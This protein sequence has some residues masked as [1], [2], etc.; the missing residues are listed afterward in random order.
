MYDKALCASLVNMII[1]HK[2][3]EKLESARS[4]I[5]FM[6][7]LWIIIP[8][9]LAFLIDTR[10][11]FK[12]SDGLLLSEN[13]VLTIVISFTIAILFIFK[14]IFPEIT[15]IIFLC[16]CVIHLLAGPSLL[17]YDFLGFGLLLNAISRG[18]PKNTKSFII[19]AYAITIL[20]SLII[21]WTVVIGSAYSVKK[22]DAYYSCT[23]SSL[24]SPKAQEC[25]RTIADF[26]IPGALFSIVVTT[27]FVI[28]GYWQR[29]NLQTIQLLQKHNEEIQSNHIQS[30]RI[31]VAAERARIA[32]DMHDIVAHTLSIIIVQSDGGRYA[33]KN[34]I[35]LARKT[36]Y[37]I[38]NE[39]ENAIHDMRKLLEAL[40]DTPSD[41][42]DLSNIPSLIKQ[43]RIISPNNIF[44]HTVDGLS[45]PEKLDNKS[46]TVAYRVV[47]ESL[48]NIRKHAGNNIKVTV[49][50]KWDKNG[51]TLKIINE[52]G[53]DAN[54]L[55]N[56]N[57]N[58]K[59]H[60]YG[61]IGM[62]ERIENIN[63]TLEY[64]K[65]EDN[66]FEIIAFIPYSSNGLAYN[67]VINPV[68]NSIDNNA[69]DNN[70]NDN[71]SINNNSSNNLKNATSY[72]KEQKENESNKNNTGNT[73]NE[74]SLNKKA[75]N[76]K[77]KYLNHRNKIEQISQWL[78]NHWLIGDII[79]RIP[80]LIVLLFVPTYPEIIGT[81]MPFGNY[82][83]SL[84]LQI[85]YRVFTLLTIIPL[86]FCRKAPSTCAII[87]AISSAI[88]LILF[89]D[90]LFANFYV[91]KI[92]YSAV[93]YG[94]KQT[95]Q[96]ISAVVLVNCAI[97]S[98]KISI[99]SL[100]SPQITT[101]IQFFTHP[102]KHYNFYDF[103]QVASANLLI[104]L[105]FSLVFFPT[106]AFAYYRRNDRNNILLLKT[107]RKE[108]EE[109]QRQ[110]QILIA[111]AE[112]Q[113]ISSNI[114]QEVSATLRRVINAA[115]SGISMLNEYQ[116]ENSNKVD[117]AK[118][119]SAKVDPAKV[120]SAKVDPAN[121]S[122]KNTND[123]NTISDNSSLTIEQIESIAEAFKH[124]GEEGRSALRYMRHLLGILRETESVSNKS[125][126]N[127]NANLALRPAESLDNQIR[128]NNS[129][130]Q[131]T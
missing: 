11:A 93:L 78:Q 75:I 58:N 47:Q 37:I 108:L 60:G 94:K 85:A 71:N 92:I 24:S 23:I 79:Y 9:L 35:F 42:L 130:Q 5:S 67:T 72:G 88:Q 45:S 70:S 6:D 65:T 114:Q 97:L 14:R 64:G 82:T 56:K 20:A 98:V 57:S 21:S 69:I 74:K 54:N 50:E 101:P 120:D 128:Q 104:S 36:M 124:I 53:K 19:S 73:S 106:I 66:S 117:T 39:A 27:F 40:K 26:S 127:K 46:Q 87:V 110:T 48:T 118:V 43:A 52:I 121:S 122:D 90:I 1:I 18:N 116:S 131:F 123:K 99:M 62:K 25:L 77:H 3:R 34:N 28:L 96:W 109:K 29:T 83:N 107:Q 55:L 86:M 4:E 7:I 22:Q 119:D 2:L 102:L 111:N 15:S 10:Y 81:N 84:T 129:T 95:W 68:I 17:S 89:P 105:I 126:K 51:L 59:S 76:K 112:R 12:I 41:T 16:V 91:I 125:A 44:W 61:L 113:R 31:A 33:A 63:G 38:R 13:T 32:R 103:I 100:N 115:D 30:Q 80:V 8:L 49:N